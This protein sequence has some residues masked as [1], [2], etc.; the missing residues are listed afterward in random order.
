MLHSN[1][2]GRSTRSI[3]K[4]PAL[5]LLSC[6]KSGSLIC[7][8]SPANTRRART[9]PKLCSNW[10]CI[11][12]SSGK[13]HDATKL[14]Q[15]LKDDF[16][17]SRPAEKATGALRRLGSLG[18]PIALRG[19]DMQGGAVD[20]ASPQYR[21]KVVLIQYWATLGERWKDDMVLLKDIYSKRGGR[22]F[23]IIGVCLDDD[24]GAAKQYLAQN[25]FPWK[26]IYEKGGLDG[27]L[28]NEMGVITLP[29]MI[30]VDQK[31]NVA[32]QNVHTAELESELAKLIKPADAA[33][34]A[35]GTSGANA[36]ANNALRPPLKPR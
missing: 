9:R 11:K 36:N 14:Y 35:A 19:T 10:V 24:P 29:L 13:A 2:C 32:N 17:T 22:D 31:G 33:A 6:K 30:L 4:R 1:Y 23:E 12:K 34:S 5:M 8:R 26:Q 25:K 28:A 18:R 15:Q 7:R 21:G 27:R 16:P 3:N 20:L